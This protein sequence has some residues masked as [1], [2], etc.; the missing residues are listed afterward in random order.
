MLIGSLRHKHLLTLMFWEPTF[1][2]SFRQELVKLAYLC[3]PSGENNCGRSLNM[4]FRTFGRKHS[5]MAVSF[6]SW[7]VWISYNMLNLSWLFLL[8][9]DDSSSHEIV[10]LS[11]VYDFN[12]VIYLMDNVIN[13]RILL[14][15]WTWYAC[16]LRMLLWRRGQGKK[17]TGGYKEEVENLTCKS[18]GLSNVLCYSWLKSDFYSHMQFDFQFDCPKT[19]ANLVSFVNLCYEILMIF[20]IVF[21][22]AIHWHG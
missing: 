22:L 5:G 21:R 4:P 8:V 17:R 11:E 19:V 7:C 13:Y 10:L 18:S 2:S 20:I 16:I 3:Y 15:V 14:Q 12:C 9:N 6:L 1:Y